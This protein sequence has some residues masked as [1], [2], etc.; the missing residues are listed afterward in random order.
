MGMVDDEELTSILSDR[1]GNRWHNYHG[2]KARTS[3]LG[4]PVRA[5]HGPRGA[6]A[7]GSCP[8]TPSGVDG[9]SALEAGNRDAMTAPF[10]YPSSPS[11]RRHGP[12]GYASR[13]SFL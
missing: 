1:Q 2:G 13:A 9:K 8:P 11:R 7:G 10:T 12:Q 6:S 3:N 4:R 5:I